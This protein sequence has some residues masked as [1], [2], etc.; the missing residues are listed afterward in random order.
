MTLCMIILDGYV[1]LEV[2]VKVTWIFLS[3]HVKY[4]TAGRASKSS[5]SVNERGK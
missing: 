2:D 4:S 1:S 3:D 5:V